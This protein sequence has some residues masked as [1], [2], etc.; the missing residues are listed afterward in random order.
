M[1]DLTQL[2]EFESS[3]N[4]VVTTYLGNY[5]QIRL[6]GEGEVENWIKDSVKIHVGHSVK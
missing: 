4:P 2:G 1:L 6:L 3:T 5:I